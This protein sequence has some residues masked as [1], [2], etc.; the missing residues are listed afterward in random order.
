MALRN[1]FVEA[2]SK[3]NLLRVRIMLKDSLLVDTSFEQ[4]NEMMHYAEQ[5]MN[6]IWISDEKD[7]EVFSQTPEELNNVLAGLVNNF[8]KRRVRCL[9]A[10]INR[11][12]PP[13][14]RK[15]KQISTKDDTIRRTREVEIEYREIKNDRRKIKDV[16]TRI[17]NENKMT[18]KDIE[19]IRN[20]ASSIVAHCDKITRKQARIW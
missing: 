7:K 19:I 10:M 1:E 16:F 14:V 3:G 2:V 18:K 15:T 8:S 4:F 20:A 5:R 9:K 12:Y 13:P 11:L 17:S 6:D